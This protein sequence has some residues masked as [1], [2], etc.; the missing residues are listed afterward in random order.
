M[1]GNMV[2]EKIQHLIISP[3]ATILEAL[4]QMDQTKKKILFVFD[5]NHFVS[6]LTIGD[7]Q[8]AIIAGRNQNEAVL[9][10]QLGPKVYAEPGEKINSVRDKMS[11]LRTDYMPV[12]D[13]AGELVD[14]ILWEDIKHIAPEE[15]RESIDLPVV[16]MAGGKGTRLRPVTNVIPKPLIP[17]GDKTILE[18][19][20]DQFIEIGCHRFY[21][22]ANYKY[23]M[24]RYY[25][26]Q[27]SYQY[28]IEYIKED[29]PLGTIGSVSLLREKMDSPFFVT[30]CDIMIN[31][32][33]RDV[34]EY[35]KNNR[36]DITII[37]ALKSYTIPYGVVETTD[38]GML[39]DI[40][41]KP[42]IAYQINTG[43]YILN[44]EMTEIIPENQYFHITQ[45]IEKVKK[46][47]GK[48]GCFPV[49]DGSWMDIGEW[50]QYLKLIDVR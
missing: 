42:E 32:D 19:I 20:M 9:G 13:Q 18:S 5:G 29:Q 2:K 45:L 39:T 14:I 1:N 6:I 11:R 41:E 50:N 31:Q 44:P 7:I 35:H 37:T 16:I 34:Y 30:N 40:Q 46:D 49:S 3:N 22:S 25:M 38:G 10:I 4:K 26:N 43:V 27:L 12:V 48:I 21:V 47:G 36:N 23:D 28:E 33:Y 24:I 15:R 8:R 17:I